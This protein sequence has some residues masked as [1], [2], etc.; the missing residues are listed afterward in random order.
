MSA[1]TTWQGLY[2]SALLELCPDELRMRINAAE[3]AIQLRIDEL[4]QGKDS[5]ED[6]SQALADALRGLRVLASTEYRSPMALSN[7]VADEAAS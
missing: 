2:R 4:R 6:E 5:S 3:K 7:L 1:N